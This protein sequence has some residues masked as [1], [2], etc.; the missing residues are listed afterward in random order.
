MYELFY[1]RASL[2]FLII[3]SAIYF[4]RI[5]IITRN[6]DFSDPE[7]TNRLIWSLA[8]C[9]GIFIL[10]LSRY[11]LF[12][13]YLLGNRIIYFIEKI[14]FCVMV[15]AL[16]VFTDIGFWFYLGF[17]LPLVM[18]TYIKGP[19]F[20]FLLVLGSMTIHLLFI[21]IKLQPML[22]SKGLELSAIRDDVYAAIVLI[23]MACAGVSFFSKLYKYRLEYEFSNV[24][25][26]EQMDERCMTLE[27]ERDRIKRE[28]TT[29]IS[30]SGELEKSNKSLSKSIAEFYTLNQISQAIGSILDTRELL[31][32][33][34][35]IILGVVGCS[36]STII[37]LDEESNRLKVHTTNITNNYEL[38]TLTD[39][40]NNGILKEALDNSECIL[41]NNVDCSKYI[42]TSGRNINSLMCIP[43][44]TTS[45]KYGLILVEHTINDAFDEENVRFLR[46]IAQQVGIVME[47]A[48]LYYKMKELARKDGLTGIYNR[49]YFQ[50][51]LEA[52][53][54][55]AKKDNCPL[56]LVIIDI[57]HFKKFNDM[58]GHIFGDKVL[59]SVAGVIASNLRKSD[60]MAR[61]GGEEF[62]I[63]LPRTN[64]AEAYEKVE[65]L[66]KLL[67]RHVIDD[68]LIS[69][70]VT[71]SFGISSFDECAFNEIDLIRTADDALYEAKAA[72]R[73]CVMT[74]RRLLESNIMH[75]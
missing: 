67:S 34:N 32:R 73:N 2:A 28:F 37:L 63:L 13:R 59:A 8:I 62:I 72:G 35:D 53:L 43:L 22:K 1:L 64:L 36:Y 44:T 65:D 23:V 70:S 42:F 51:R 31:K 50:E 17:F 10:Q 9:A 74:A 40:I 6:V 56:S 69:V 39:H 7:Q 46:I 68:N 19:R 71:A 25:T 12:H 16:A 5:L 24:Y 30:S 54:S 38:A 58:Y 41:E 15:S 48:E 3:S 66:R 52:E 61:Y 20:G 45:R 27:S 60:V 18:A 29:L 33:L 55:Q 11:Y 14:L 75:N 26:L 4:F 21:Y 49:Q 47:N 57:D